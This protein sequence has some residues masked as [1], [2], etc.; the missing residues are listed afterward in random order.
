VATL[1]TP[2]YFYGMAPGDE[3]GVEIEQGKTLVIR[4][5]ALG[6]TEDD[7]NVRVF[8]ELN[9]QPRIVNVA[10]RRAAAKAGARRR[11]E[12]GNEAH[13]AAPMPGVVAV[14]AITAGQKVQ[15]GD[16]LMTLEAMK[17]E[18]AITA[19]RDGSIGEVLVRPGQ[20]VDAKDLLAVLA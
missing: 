7:G 3:I 15:A 6:E 18:T 10:N 13:I 2:T 16:L 1:P 19:P 17:M 4:L 12:A 8:F 5:Q 14:L 11:A 9:G 20:A